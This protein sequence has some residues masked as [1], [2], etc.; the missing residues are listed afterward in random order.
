MLPKPLNHIASI[1]IALIPLAYLAYVWNDLPANIGL[2]FNVIGE[3]DRSGD[4]NGLL[5]QIST[6]SALTILV[7]FL[8]INA[9]KLDKKRLKGIKPPTFDTIA[10]ATVLFMTV[11][12]LGIILNGIY[13]A[14]GIFS[15]LMLPAIGLFF[16][17]MG[18]V[19]YNIKPN[20][21]VGIRIPWTL[22]DEDNW[23]HTHRLG[24]KLFFVGGILITIVSVAYDQ[25]IAAAFMSVTVTLIALVSILY[26]YLF[27]RKNKQH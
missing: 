5:M 26:S 21:F 23:R 6:V 19:M 27:Y 2:H 10:L 17:F 3:A 13:P 12:N 11:I 20:K 8:V 1:L 7:Y 22:N 18:N 16:V 14:S 4:K 9:H 15:K 25:H 24:S